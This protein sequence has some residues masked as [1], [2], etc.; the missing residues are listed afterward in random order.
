MGVKR[1]YLLQGVARRQVL[2]DVSNHN[3]FGRVLENYIV[4]EEIVIRLL[5][6]GFY[7]NCMG[8]RG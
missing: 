8:N 7:E 3:L 2:G 1:Y 6:A 5:I 4:L